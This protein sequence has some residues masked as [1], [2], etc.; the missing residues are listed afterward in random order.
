VRSVKELGAIIHQAR[1]QK[2][3]TLEDV[4]QETRIRTQFLI[5][6]EEGE[7]H[8]IPGE[9]YARAFI[10]S[11]AKVVGLDPDE[12]M[13]QYDLRK[14]PPD[15]HDKPSLRERRAEA[16]RRRRIRAVVIVLAGAAVAL[17]VYLLWKM[18]YFPL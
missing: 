13:A 6:I 9:A 3:L 8:E 18:G 14:N 16:R 11:Y 17:V 5:A 2:G 12:M 4:E 10:R 1:K 15:L 7:L